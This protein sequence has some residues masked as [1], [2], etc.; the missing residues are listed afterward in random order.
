[1][2]VSV[3]PLAAQQPQCPLLILAAIR[4]RC[5]TDRARDDKRRCFQAPLTPLNCN[6]PGYVPFEQRLMPS[7]S[8][9]C[10]HCQA[11]IRIDDALAGQATECQQCGQRLFVPTA[12]PPP[13][14]SAPP[15]VTRGPVSAPAP[16]IRITTLG[17]AKPVAKAP[18]DEQPSRT[19][20]RQRKS[21][22]HLV[23]LVGGVAVLAITVLV[24]LWLTDHQASLP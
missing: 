12:A 23:M 5:Q 10:P 3:R 9:R 18:I 14:A 6:R 21:L 24:L 22:I 16:N 1:M 19:K 20:G 2:R 7:L 11:V 4:L 15:V 17:T 13:I 8:V